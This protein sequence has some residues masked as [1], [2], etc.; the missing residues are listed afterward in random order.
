MKNSLT[1]KVGIKEI[2]FFAGCLTI[3]FLIP[4]LLYAWSCGNWK[5][6]DPCRTAQDALEFSIMDSEEITN[7][8]PSHPDSIFDSRFFSDKDSE[9]IMGIMERLAAMTM[10]SFEN[11]TTSHKHEDEMTELSEYSSQAGI[12][13]QAMMRQMSFPSGSDTGKFS[14]WKVKIIYDKRTESGKVVKLQKWFAIDPTGKHV[15]Q[16]YDL[17]VFNLTTNPE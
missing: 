17:P 16:S 7:V 13:L 15:L 5:T 10:S 11:A 14:G 1:K 8:I 6:P 2:L 9:E 3:M 12:A 4:F